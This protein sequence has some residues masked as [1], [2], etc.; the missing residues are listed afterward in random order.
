[1]AFESQ[2]D[3][4]VLYHKNCL[5]GL[6][7]AWVA[8]KYHEGKVDLYPVQYGGRY[9]EDF[10]EDF[11]KLLNKTVYCLDFSFD[12][13][14]TEHLLGIC[15]PFI[16]LDHHDTAWKNLSSIAVTNIGLESSLHQ[17]LGV[18]YKGIVVVD[19]TKSGATLTWEWF[20]GSD[21]DII[22]PG[23]LYVEDRD[24]WKW[25][26]SGSRSWTSCAF[27]YEKTVA[28]FDML[29]YTAPEEVI[30]E[31]KAIERQMASAIKVIGKSERRFKIDEFDVPICNAN[32]LFA[33]DLGAQM[34][35]GEAFS[36]TYVDGVDSRQYSLRSRDSGV[37]VNEIAERFGGGGHPGAAGF[38]ILFTDP[39]F[40]HSHEYL[41]SV[42]LVYAGGRW[43]K[44]PRYEEQK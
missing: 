39:Q 27:S 5:D 28:N 32:S 18:T 17:Q 36:I 26:L 31:G 29:M 16:V 7:A 34:A 6:A 38:R 24:L 35:A 9:E 14:T 12:K 8:W 30:R 15:R 25:K 2:H 10:G 41:E 13:E 37:K 22:P 11:C 42:R 21:L 3:T 4:V 19:Q 40:H 20:Y 23:L 1:M 44:A 43:I 33:S